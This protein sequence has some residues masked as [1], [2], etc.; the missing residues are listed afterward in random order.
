MV[1]TGTVGGFHNGET[2]SLRTGNRKSKAI[3]VVTAVTFE[4]CAVKAG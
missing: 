3:G 2:S 1:I 4:N